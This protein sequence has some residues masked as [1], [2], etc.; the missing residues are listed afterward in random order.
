MGV[1][2]GWGVGV[3]DLSFFFLSPPLVITG[4]GVNET[5]GFDVVSV[6]EFGWDGELFGLDFLRADLG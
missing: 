3:V 4:C 6:V 1:G 5:N 2:S